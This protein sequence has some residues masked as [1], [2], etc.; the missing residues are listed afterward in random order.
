MTQITPDQVLTRAADILEPE[1]RWL[2]G[3][4]GAWH[5]NGLPPIGTARYTCF[6]LVGALSEAT[7]QLSDEI[8]RQSMLHARA[9]PYVQQAIGEPNIVAWNDR[10]GR[11]QAEVVAALR[12]A[13]K[14]AKGEKE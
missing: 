9:E 5:D 1:G 14:F 4:Y 7:R 2:Q 10:P 3:S 11:T 13:A 12:A 6:C 8:L